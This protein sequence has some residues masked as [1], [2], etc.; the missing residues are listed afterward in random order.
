M[1]GTALNGSPWEDRG[2]ALW[3]GGAGL[4][5][6]LTRSMATSHSCPRKCIPQAPTA[7][8]TSLRAQAGSCTQVWRSRAGVGGVAASHLPALES[9]AA[10]VPQFPH[11]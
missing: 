5:G 10:G 8:N 9:W 6:Q 4:E 3:M 2:A 1:G 7:A 11:L